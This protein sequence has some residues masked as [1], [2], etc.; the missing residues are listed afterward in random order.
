MTYLDCLPQKIYGVL[1]GIKGIRELRL[2]DN[3]PVRV[4]VEG[5]WLWAGDVALQTDCRGAP[6]FPRLC[7]EFIH[8]ACNNSL[9]AYEKT[10]AQG[11]FTLE[12][13]TRVGVCGDMGSKGVFR[14]Y[15]SLCLRIAKHVSC[16]DV[17][18]GSV[19]AAGPPCS[20]K[21]T[22]LRD[23]ACKLSLCANVVV[24]DERG[25]LSCGG[26]LAKTNCD[27][28]RFADK[29]YAVTSAVRTLSPQWI[30]CDELSPQDVEYL[31]YAAQ[32]GVK[33]A[34]SI[35]ACSLAD[36]ADKLGKALFCFDTAVLLQPDT[37]LQTKT[38]LSKF[39]QKPLLY[40]EKCSFV[41]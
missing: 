39:K 5:K 26:L 6:V 37:F 29:Q 11:Y 35:H 12:D 4:N 8:A 23:L 36:A 27:V 1:H 18:S 10:L 13:G 19:L 21:T 9:Y 14:E 41:N 33:V 2:R 28:M 7:A 16:A 15:T 40:D 20:G 31:L 24:V 25:E 30:V 38:D 34:A 22:F 3:R 17:Y 32:S